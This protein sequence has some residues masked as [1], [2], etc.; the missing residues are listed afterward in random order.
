MRFFVVLGRA[1]LS[2][3]YNLAMGAQALI[4]ATYETI[5]DDP[6]PAEKEEPETESAV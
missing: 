3:A 5:G 6:L 1:T 2:A 4:E